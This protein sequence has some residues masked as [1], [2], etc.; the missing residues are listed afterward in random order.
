MKRLILN[1][2][3][4]LSHSQSK[5]IEV[6]FC[7]GLN[8]IVGGNK[9]G[10]SSLIKSVFDCFGCK[11]KMESRWIDVVTA[12]AVLFSY[13]T[14]Q[15][16][17]VKRD[18]IR[19]LYFFADDDWRC[20]VT[21]SDFDKFNKAFM[22]E[23]DIN[24]PCVPHR[25]SSTIIPPAVLFA[26]Q[27]ID[28]DA[29]WTGIAKSFSN[30]SNTKNWRSIIANLASGYHT[31]EYFELE[32]QI[33]A[34]KADKKDKIDIH[35]MNLSFYERLKK[36]ALVAVP[37]S[38]I[39]PEEQAQ[40]AKNLLLQ[41][42]GFHSELIEV[43]SRVRTLE[44]M[45]YRANL[46]KQQ[47][48]TQVREVQKDIEF[49]LK[50]ED[51]LICPCC[52]AQYSNTLDHHLH[53]SEDISICET[54]II[55]LEQDLSAWSNELAQLKEKAQ[56][57][58]NQYQKVLADVRM[59]QQNTSHEEFIKQKGRE[60]IL[61]RGQEDLEQLEAEI[62]RIESAIRESTKAKRKISSAKRKKEITDAIE[63]QCVS[64]A[65]RI[66]YPAERVKL[67]NF[68]QVSDE[69]GS[70]SPKC[71]YMYYVAMYLYNLKREASPFNMLVVDTPNQQGQDTLSLDSILSTLELLSDKSGQFIL[72]TE[73]D[74]GYEEKAA[75]VFRLTKQRECLDDMQ[76]EEHAAFFKH[77]L[78]IC[79][80]TQATDEQ[81][82]AFQTE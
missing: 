76:Y 10:K 16:C 72:C 12:A 53:L 40:K 48:A 41:A 36:T 23:L 58:R 4:I 50:S 6:P 74:T 55:Q 75:N 77:L 44:R 65:E 20:I 71:I 69:T 25:G 13:G 2:L 11:T 67:H 56:L 34:L 9:T 78:E 24:I 43:E 79:L 68:I 5:S 64:I 57:L 8:I 37:E 66:R 3:L 28:Q 82:I 19:D 15:Y 60:E 21:T 22:K 42:D 7:E 45:I 59:I 81:E 26:L 14:T 63:T 17:L 70:D 38:V 29:G 47:Y 30:S 35:E 1:K 39:D 27:Y 49:A 61:E 73:R 62:S 52:G 54:A 32:S 51:T 46:N 31:E 33:T 80:N 18:T